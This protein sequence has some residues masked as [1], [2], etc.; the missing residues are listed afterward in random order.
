MND[1]TRRKWAVFAALLLMLCAGIGV[2]ALAGTS[3]GDDTGELTL[4]RYTVP[5][6]APELL[7]SVDRD[8]NVPATAGGTTVGLVCDDGRGARV[9]HSQVEWPFIEEEGFPRPHVH[10]AA[11]DTELNRIATCRLTGTSIELEG[12]LGLR[13]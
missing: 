10:Q 6:G 7:V 8:V 2:V 4:E 3:G 13:R 5:G 12:R 11:S 9:L 1:G